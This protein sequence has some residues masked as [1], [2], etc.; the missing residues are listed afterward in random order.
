MDEQRE[1]LAVSAAYLAV[2][3]AAQSSGL[4]TA[5]DG[6]FAARFEE[7]VRQKF[8]GMH[9]E[10]VLRKLVGHDKDRRQQGWGIFLPCPGDEQN[11][12]L[13]ATGYER[14]SF[15]VPETQKIRTHEAPA[16]EDKIPRHSQEELQELPLERLDA[17]RA[18]W[19]RARADMEPQLKAIEIV[20]RG[21]AEEERQRISAR[22]VALEEDQH[23]LER[24]AACKAGE[25]AALRNKLG[26]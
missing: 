9:A 12:M 19:L 6:R 22:I 18:A 16:V 17:L 10:T 4:H 13:C 11:F 26:V 20:R 24:Q 25:I 14:F 5:R 3:R 21:K 1:T 7:W 8:S 23:R 2:I 15:V